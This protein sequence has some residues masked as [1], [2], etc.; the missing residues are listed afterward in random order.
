MARLKGYMT[1][2]SPRAL[3]LGGEA[4]FTGVGIPRHI[5]GNRGHLPPTKDKK[6]SLNEHTRTDK[7]RGRL[8]SPLK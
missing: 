4:T 1:Q 3:S 5:T 2:Q 6:E 7:F 8:S